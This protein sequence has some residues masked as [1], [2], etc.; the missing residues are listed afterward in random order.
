MH[1]KKECNSIDYFLE[2]ELLTQTHCEDAFDRL[3][4]EFPN[5][6]SKFTTKSGLKSHMDREHRGKK[7]KCKFCAKKL[8]SQFSVHRHILSAHSNDEHEEGNEEENEQEKKAEVVYDQVEEIV[9]QEE[10]D[11]LIKQQSEK[12]VQLENEWKDN[13]Q[14][15]KILRQQLKTISSS[16]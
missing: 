11:E 13:Q 15:I 12:I 9:P 16:R 3:K 5:C 7:F 10:E 4:C 8:A 1:Y 2:R 6:S 14:Q